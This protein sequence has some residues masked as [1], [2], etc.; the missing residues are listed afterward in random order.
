MAE[1][2]VKSSSA[3]L[4]QAWQVLRLSRQT[5]EDQV[6]R[7]KAARVWLHGAR[8]WSEGTYWLILASNDQTG[9]EKFFLSNAPADTPVEVLV[10][11][12]F[13]R[14]HV[15]H[16]FRLCKAELGFTHF[17][18]RNYVALMRHWTLCLSAMGFVAEHT[19]RL[20]GEKPRADDGASLPGD[21]PDV[22]ELVAAAAAD[23]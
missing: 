22:P 4:G 10:R 16:G 11:V 9:E 2:V 1:E 17:E 6:W 18:G 15:E 12:A 23:Q 20:R 21:G 14:F 5:R 13:R 19:E 3:F 8:G 7:V